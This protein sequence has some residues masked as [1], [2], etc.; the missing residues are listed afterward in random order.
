M[1]WGYMYGIPSLGSLTGANA[2]SSTPPL[3][4]KA[5]AHACMVSKPSQACARG[6]LPKDRTG[7]QGLP[8]IKGRAFRVV[9]QADTLFVSAVSGV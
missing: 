2:A 1:G 6:A 7:G 4:W 5:L 8:T 3:T 9:W